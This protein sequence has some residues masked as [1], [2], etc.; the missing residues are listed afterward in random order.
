RGARRHHHGPWLQVHFMG[1]RRTWFAI[2]GA[3]IAIAIVSLGVRGLNFGIDFKGGS[4]VTFQ[5][6]QPQLVADVRTDAQSI[7]WSLSKAVIQG[8]GASTDGKYKSFQ[9]RT[10][11]L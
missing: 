2:S 9:L 7:D 4:Q 6:P 1:R 11:A 5:T 3:I 8:R 10:K